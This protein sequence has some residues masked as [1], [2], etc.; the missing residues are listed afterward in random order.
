MTNLLKLN[1]LNYQTG[2]IKKQQREENK[3]KFYKKFGSFKDSK[4]HKKLLERF[5]ARKKGVSIH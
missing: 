2:F 1:D 3:W 4:Q 5:L